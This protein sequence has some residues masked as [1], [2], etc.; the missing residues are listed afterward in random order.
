MFIGPDQ[1]IIPVSGS[2]DLQRNCSGLSGL[3]IHAKSLRR[4]MGRMTPGLRDGVAINLYKIPAIDFFS[5]FLITHAIS[6]GHWSDSVSSLCERKTSPRIPRVVRLKKRC[7]TLCRPNFC[8]S[9]SSAL[10]RH[11]HVCYEVERKDSRYRQMKLP[12][13]GLLQVQ[14]SC[15]GSQKAKGR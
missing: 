5:K 4:E 1:H 11:I 3:I 6:S 14:I 8:A 7:R 13:I 9:K 12:F 2:L 10:V 15:Q